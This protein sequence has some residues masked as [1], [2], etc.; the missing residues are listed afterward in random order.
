MTIIFLKFQ[1]HGSLISSIFTDDTNQTIFD[2][3]FDQTVTITETFYP[4]FEF[5]D[6]LSKTGG[7][8]GLWL[9]LGLAQLVEYVVIVGKM[10][11]RFPSM[12]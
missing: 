9:G 5:L 2:F 6:F 8:I 4:A 10:L 1:I 11:K 7:A 12:K 3:T